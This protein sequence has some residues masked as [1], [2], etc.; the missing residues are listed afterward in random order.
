MARR[1]NMVE[2]NIVRRREYDGTISFSTKLE[3]DGVVVALI[4]GEWDTELHDISMFVSPV[5]TTKV[6]AQFASNNNILM[7]RLFA[8][9]DDVSSV[10]EALEMFKNYRDSISVV[11]DGDE[12]IITYKDKVLSI[13][14]M[15][16]NNYNVM[17]NGVGIIAVEISGYKGGYDYAREVSYRFTHCKRKVYTCVINLKSEEYVA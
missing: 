6:G 10:D 4:R 7:Q 13:F 8:S 17:E 15:G 11:G 9:A 2:K 3:L 14:K 5:F 1:N 12:T 16:S